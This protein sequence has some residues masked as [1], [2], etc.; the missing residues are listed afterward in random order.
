MLYLGIDQHARQL[1]IS[2]RDED[3][4]VLMARQVST[5]PE[6]IQE[7]FQRICPLCQMETTA[8][9]KKRTGGNGG[10]GE[11][12]SLLPPSAL[13]PRTTWAVTGKR[14]SVRRDC[15]DQWLIECRSRCGWFLN[16]H[17]RIMEEL[18]MK[19]RLPLEA[20]RV[21]LGKRIVPLQSNG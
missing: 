12:R 19:R 18:W 8:S 7:F 10:N 17:D 13:L 9:L 21:L 14:Q 16:R 2:L 5:R 4:D 11:V 3:G 6:K 15:L 20:R 1:T